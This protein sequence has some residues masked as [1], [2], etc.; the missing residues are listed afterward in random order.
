MRVLRQ[1]RAP[2]VIVTMI[3]RIVEPIAGLV[4]VNIPPSH[5]WNPDVLVW[6]SYDA[7]RPIVDDPGTVESRDESPSSQC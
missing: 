1:E 3:G 7:V 6:V 5:R 4:M 2:G